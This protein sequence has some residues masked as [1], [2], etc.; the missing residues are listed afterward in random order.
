MGWPTVQL[1]SIGWGPASHCTQRQNWVS[2]F[3]NLVIY[4]SCQVNEPVSSG[5]CTVQS[6]Q[7][8][9]ALTGKLDALLNSL[10]LVQVTC[11]E[12]EQE[13]LCVCRILMEMHRHAMGCAPVACLC[14]H[15]CLVIVGSQCRR[16]LLVEEPERP[17]RTAPTAAPTSMTAVPLARPLKRPRPTPR[18][19][20]LCLL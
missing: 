1:L 20:L 8:H 14:A 16:F 10:T 5:H 13:Q 12:Q 9:C 6:M 15:H 4:S 11:S 17:P 18:E 2:Q 19:P 7:I 3:A